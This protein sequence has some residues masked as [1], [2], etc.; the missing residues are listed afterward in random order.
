MTIPGV[1]TVYF[2]FTLL[3]TMSS[4]QLK[5]MKCIKYQ[6]N[7]NPL[8]RDTA[9]DRTRCRGDPKVEAKTKTVFVMSGCHNKT[10]QTARVKQQKC[11]S[12]GS[13]GWEFQDQGAGQLVPGKNALPGV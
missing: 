13:A 10:P 8:S 9:T 1:I 11:I 2:S 4:I 6:N 3:N 12:H 7:Y 5:I